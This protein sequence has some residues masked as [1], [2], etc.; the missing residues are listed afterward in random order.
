MYT[1]TPPI[2]NHFPNKKNKLIENRLTNIRELGNVLN[3]FRNPPNPE[4]EK[5]Y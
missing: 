1:S 2:K 5:I 4:S 3:K